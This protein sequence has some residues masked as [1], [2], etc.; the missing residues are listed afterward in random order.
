MGAPVPKRSNFETMRISAL[1]VAV[2]LIV[3]SCGED[4]SSG[5][6]FRGELARVLADPEAFDGRRVEVRAWLVERLE[7]QVLTSGLAESYPPQAVEPTV[8]LRA[9]RPLGACLTSDAGTSWGR[10]RASGVFRYEPRG[11][12]GPLGV[13]PMAL[14]DAS[15]ACA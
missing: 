5:P 13:L 7:A 9:S 11:A 10:V 8:W 4:P 15:L 3:A 6:P 2:G 14:V 1:V 12:F